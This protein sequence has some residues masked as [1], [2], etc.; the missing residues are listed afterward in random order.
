MSKAIKIII[1]NSMNPL[2]L[3]SIRYILPQTNKT[4]QSKFYSAT[5]LF[6]ADALM[7]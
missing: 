7:L 5:L 3:L 6:K 2:S 4:G 1:I